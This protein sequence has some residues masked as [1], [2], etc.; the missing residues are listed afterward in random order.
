M[1][2]QSRRNTHTNKNS[3]NSLV[4][5]PAL[6]QFDNDFINTTDSCHKIIIRVH[7]SGDL[8][9][10]I[11]TL[12]LVLVKLMV[13][14]SEKLRS[15]QQ[16]LVEA[17]RAQ[18][19]CVYVNIKTIFCLALLTTLTNLVF[20][21]NLYTSLLDDTRNAL[22]SFSSGAGSPK[23]TTSPP[24]RPAVSSGGGGWGWSSKF[25]QVFFSFLPSLLEAIKIDPQ[26]HQSSEIYLRPFKITK[27]K[28]YSL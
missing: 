11:R 4:K 10:R 3:S 21:Q 19:V 6:F 20:T 25:Y 15:F 18:T 13:K 8:F 22:M 7:F 5:N 26:G 1:R 14:F 28:I 16:T 2:I 23:P 27:M 17:M 24:L 9:V 12:N